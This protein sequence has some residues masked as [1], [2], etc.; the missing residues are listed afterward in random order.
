VRVAADTIDI[1]YNGDD[2]QVFAS[3]LHTVT[4]IQ[5]P[6]YLYGEAGNGSILA[7]TPKM[8]PY[9]LNLMEST[10]DVL[11]VTSDGKSM[12]VAKDALLDGANAL[13]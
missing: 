4:E 7:F 10:D 11:S 1:V 9:E 2:T 13:N 12:T 5:W 3:Q 6:L 8:L